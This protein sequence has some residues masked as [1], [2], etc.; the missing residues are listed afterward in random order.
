MTSATSERTAAPVDEMA[1]WVALTASVLALKITLLV[2]DPLPI[3]FLGDSGSYLHSA[4]TSQAPLDRSFTYGLDFVRP[5]LAVFRSLQTV[6]VIQSLLAAASSI[7]AGM[8]LR[9]GFRA[10]LWAA[11]VAGLLY[12]LEPLALIY[13]RLILTETLSL[14][15]FACFVLTGL[16]YINRPRLWL[17]I[18]LAFLGTCI[19]S[20]RT[21]YIP[22]ILAATAAAVLLAVPHLMQRSAPRLDQ[23]RLRKLLLHALVALGA[24]AGFHAF[25][26]SYFSYLTTLPP[27][28]NGGDG[29]FLLGSWAPLVTAAD[30][31]STEMADTLLPEVK[32]ELKNRFS[33]PNQLFTRGGLIDLLTKEEGGDY[34]KANR[35]AKSTALH[36]G[37]RDPLGVAKL[38]SLTYG[39][40]WDGEMMK[41]GLLVAQGQRELD[42]WLLDH[43]LVHYAEDLSGRY[44]HDSIAKW[45]HRSAIPWY[46][47]LL[48][49]PLISLLLC[50]PRALRNESIFIAVIVW[51]VFVVGVALV[52]GPIVRYLHAIAWLMCIQIGL[53]LYLL[54]AA[55]RGDAIA[56]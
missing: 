29:F 39:D 14:F 8:C 44:L 10:P 24:T 56:R 32:F 5:I 46:R 20:L 19:L 35:V 37:L 28:Y 15:F 49:S 23:F 27:A 13:E 55:R 11:A 30:L 43:F 41:Q 7:L 53:S 6:V 50:I 34:R 54:H 47:F 9:V 33:R 1:F 52:L 21:F 4:L 31:P 26:Q 18:A 38:A 51:A 36:A 48:L 17:L 3:F 2:L 25:Y 42:Q 40:F 16:C 45:W 12:A 22:A